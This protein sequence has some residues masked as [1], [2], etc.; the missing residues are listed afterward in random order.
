VISAPDVSSLYDIPVNFEKD[1][2]GN[3][4]L[5]KLS[6]RPRAKDMKEW[7]GSRRRSITRKMW[8]VSASSENISRAEIYFGG[9]VSF[10]H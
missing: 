3:L 4:I 1:D 5:E 10:R 7:R 6:M 9:L 2:L 8:C